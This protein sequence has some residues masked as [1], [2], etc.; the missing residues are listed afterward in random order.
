[1]QPLPI[2]SRK[3]EV[4]TMDFVTS[5]PKTPEGF[6]AIMIMVDKLTKRIFLAPTTDNVDAE[7]YFTST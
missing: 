2:P 4:I 3:F 5:L 7:V 1:L 6:T